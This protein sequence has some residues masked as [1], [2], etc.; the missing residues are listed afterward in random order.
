[1]CFV[2]RLPTVVEDHSVRGQSPRAGRPV[3]QLFSKTKRYSVE[4]ATCAH[5]EYLSRFAFCRSTPRIQEFL[6]RSLLYYDNNERSFRTVGP[7][8]VHADKN[9]PETLV[10]RTILAEYLAVLNILQIR[11]DSGDTAHGTVVN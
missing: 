3:G 6:Q 7:L 8:G 5:I 2:V 10:E 4:R 1:M 11:R 9:S